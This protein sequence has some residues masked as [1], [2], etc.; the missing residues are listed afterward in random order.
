MSNSSSF[1][2]LIDLGGTTYVTRKTEAIINGSNHLMNKEIYT[3]YG[4]YS[5]AKNFNPKALIDKASKTKENNCYFSSLSIDE[6]NGVGNLIPYRAECECYYF[7]SG[8][9]IIDFKKEINANE[10]IDGTITVSRNIMVRAISTPTQNDPIASATALVKTFSG[11][12][13][14]VNLFVK[15]IP[16]AKNTILASE[17]FNVDKVNGIVNLTQ[18]YI[19]N[20]KKADISKK[21]IIKQTSEYQSGIDGVATQTKRTIVIGGTGM[22]DSTL[23]GIGNTIQM[24]NLKIIG[25]NVTVDS[26]SNTVDI[27]SVY[28]NDETIDSTIGCKCS[29]SLSFNYDFISNQHSAVYSAEAF[30]ASAMISGSALKQCLITLSDI[31]QYDPCNLS[32]SSIGTTTGESTLSL[33]KADNYS[34]SPGNVS[35]GGSSGFNASVQ[36]NYQPGYHYNVA[37]PVVSGK[38]SW[39][40]EDMGLELNA[41]VGGTVSLNYGDV[42]PTAGDLYSLMESGFPF[43]ANGQVVRDEMMIDKNAKKA[44]YTF[45]TITPDNIFKDLAK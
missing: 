30:P 11:E 22:P 29:N 9:G 14:P 10:N 40:I 1:P 41:T 25:K 2:S 28:S 43:K 12:N 37:S 17:I 24:G 45:L 34:S 7:R 38:G 19:E 26:G 15:T 23:E 4:E 21:G 31:K 27:A 8:E 3:A 5:G 13:I 44:T 32:F 39:Y 18:N 36:I 6:T 33:I 16:D 20:A 42:T 35:F